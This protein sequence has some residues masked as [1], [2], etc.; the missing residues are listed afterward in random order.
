MERL[1]DA[2]RPF[3]FRLL[4]LFVL[5]ISTTSCF[6]I[7]EELS[8]HKDGSGNL[9][10]TLN[11][12]QSKSK[13]ASVMLL[14]TIQGHKVPS[15]KDIKEHIEELVS[16]LNASEGISN[17]TYKLNLDSYIVS[18]SCDFKEVANINDFV[19]KLWDKQRSKGTFKSYSFDVGK[20]LFSRYYGFK[21][22]L[23][24]SV[25]S[26]K[27]DDKK[28]LDNASYTLIYRFDNTVKSFSNRTARLSK[29]KKAMMMKTPIMDIVSGASTIENKIQ[30]T[31]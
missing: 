13:L 5:L 9:Q 29:S 27:D 10:L 30:L 18:L 11:A 19:Q 1:S 26:L 20:Q 14:D 23:K 21:D 15:K 8:L 7:I 17:V 24:N 25:R 16:D 28:V 31:N 4:F 6:E 2:M 22:N 12:S 3:F